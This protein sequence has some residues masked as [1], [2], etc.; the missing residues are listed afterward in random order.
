M[1]I[2]EELSRNIVR[3]STESFETV[4]TE[5]G[6]VVKGLALPFNKVSRNG[7]TYTSE[8]IKSTFNTLKGTSV[9]FNH[10]PNIIL[11]HVTESKIGPKGLEYVV[12]LDN[13]EESLIRKIKRGD[14]SKVSIQVMFDPETSFVS[15]ESGVTHAVIEEF[16]ELSFVSIPGFADTTAQV[17]EGLRIKSHKEDNN[18][19]SEEKP[20]E[21]PKEEPKKEQ[22]EPEP[23]EEPK[24][25]M[26]EMKETVGKLS[27]QI[28]AINDRID[29]ME[30]AKTEADDKEEDEKER[31]EAIKKDKLPI[32]GEATN[33][34][35][36]ITS[37]DLKQAFKEARK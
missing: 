17:V 7:F 27:A 36:K 28:S 31:E 3:I 30:G 35:K 37:K 34:P 9:L 20:K 1:T 15:E 24:D 11:G 22:T 25:P 33:T 5:K 6:V 16:L 14:L 8:S 26:E 10:D 32:A 23:E 4:K 12:D 2:K 18:K 29:K 19:M 13:G 21:E